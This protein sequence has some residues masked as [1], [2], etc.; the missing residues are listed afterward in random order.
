M[1]RARLQPCRNINQR[2]GA[3]APQVDMPEKGDF[4]ML[5]AS[6]DSFKSNDQ[7]RLIGRFDFDGHGEFWNLVP[8]QPGLYRLKFN[9]NAYYVGQGKSIFRRLGDYYQP[10][11]GIESDHRIH[12]AL[13]KFNGA[14]VEVMTGD[15][16]LDSSVRRKI[17]TAEIDALRARGMRVLNGHPDCIENLQDR[18]EYYENEIAKLR[19]KIAAL[20]ATAGGK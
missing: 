4:D 1:L 19:E 17:E 11:Q 10:G 14:E 15:Q 9:E 13:H 8:D 3:L 7:W 5:D 16:F 12:R 20:T 2:K 6:A 18:I